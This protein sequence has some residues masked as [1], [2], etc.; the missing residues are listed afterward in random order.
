MI[1]DTITALFFSGGL[2][3]SGPAAGGVNGTI[4]LGVGIGINGG[5]NSGPWSELSPLASSGLNGFGGLYFQG[6]A[7]TWPGGF[8]S[9]IPPVVGTIGRTIGG[10]CAA[11]L[12]LCPII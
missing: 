5:I 2:P 10:A 9:A 4:G 6:G 11:Q 3:T 7:T 8:P 12:E 1:P